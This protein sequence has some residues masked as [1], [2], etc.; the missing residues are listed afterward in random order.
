VECAQS[1]DEVRRT[2][3]GI[4]SNPAERVDFGGGHAVGDHEKFEHHPPTA[5][6]V[7]RVAAV[8]GE[9]YPVYGLLTLFGVPRV[10]RT[11]DT[12][13]PLDERCK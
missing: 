12:I 9:R 5:E 3:G 13:D 2:H 10:S 8:V 6:Q 4:S 11:V 7:G 1:S